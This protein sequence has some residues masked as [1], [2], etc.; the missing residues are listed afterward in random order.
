MRELKRTTTPKRIW[1]NVERKQKNAMW[2]AL[3]MEDKMK[4]FR[5]EVI[6]YMLSQMTREQY[7]WEHVTPLS[8]GGKATPENTVVSTKKY[9]LKKGAKTLPE[10]IEKWWK[11]EE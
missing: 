1:A 10:H 11:G 7:H 8:K 9:N 6:C 2:R 4:L 5:I 3:P